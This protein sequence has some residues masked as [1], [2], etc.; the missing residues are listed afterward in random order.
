MP[1]FSIA[2]PS[3]SR[4]LRRPPLDL[5]T[6]THVKAIKNMMAIL[7]FIII[8][9]AKSLDRMMNLHSFTVITYF[10]QNIQSCKSHKE[11]YGFVDIC[12]TFYHHVIP[13]LLLL[14]YVKVI[15]IIIIR[16][17]ILIIIIYYT[18]SGRVSVS[19]GQVNDPS[20]Y[21]TLLS[22]QERMSTIP[23]L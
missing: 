23:V 16:E 3:V 10:W 6:S 8:F 5:R 9:F 21:T 22:T 2:S 20:V 12:R 15:N 17:L 18:I 1:A 7:I 4:L 13:D 19:G 11:R 14:L